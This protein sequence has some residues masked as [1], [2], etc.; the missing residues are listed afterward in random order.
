VKGIWV[1]GCPPSM[2]V[3]AASKNDERRT[4]LGWNIDCD[5]PLGEETV[6][7]EAGEAAAGVNTTSRSELG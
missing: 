2:A 3:I 1:S 6:A 7:E 5:R 4:H